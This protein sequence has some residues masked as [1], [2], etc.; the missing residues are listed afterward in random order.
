MTE[1]T[2]SNEPL[3]VVKEKTTITKFSSVPRSNDPLD[4]AE[5]RSEVPR[6]EIANEPRLT[7]HQVE[8]PLN[9]G[10]TTNVIPTNLV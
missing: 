10:L 6:E 8:K 2:L 7:T 9:E 3:K 5:K 1:N 4:I